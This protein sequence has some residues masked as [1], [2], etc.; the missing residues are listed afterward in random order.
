MTKP[1]TVRERQ[2]L[3]VWHDGET[4]RYRGEVVRIVRVRGLHLNAVVQMG[5]SE[6]FTVGLDRLSVLDVG[7]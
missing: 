3:G 5:E 7:A 4:A 2:E 1:L 6:P